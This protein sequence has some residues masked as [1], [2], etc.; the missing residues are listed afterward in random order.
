MRSSMIDD[1]FHDPYKRGVMAD[2]DGEGSAGETECGA[3][4][5]VYIR[6]DGLRISEAAFTASGSKAAI[7]C[8]SVLA[9]MLEGMSWKQA[10][11]MPPASIA[12]AL[13]G[14]EGLREFL[15]CRDAGRP[16]R[17]GS[18]P[19]AAEFA[20]D[21]LHGALEKAISNGSFPVEKA[22]SP[23][24]VIVAMSGGV[25]S[26]VACLL[27]ERSRRDVIGVTMRLWSD[28]LCDN[29]GN[30]SSSCCS[31]RT[32][33]DARSVCQD[34]GVPHLTIDLRERFK[35]SVVE[36]FVSEYLAG[37]TP[38]PCTR[39]NAG[40][41]FPALAE[42]AERLGAAA[43]ATGHYARI[44]KGENAS[45]LARGHDINKDQSYML[46]GIE[47]ALLGKLEF[48]L[49]E[50]DKT[51]T[52]NMARRSSLPVHNRPESQEVCF[53][54]DDDYRRFIA[55]RLSA[56]GGELPGAGDIVD[57]SGNLLGRHSGF[58][59]YTIGQRRGLGISAPEPLYVISSHPPSNLIVVGRREELAVDRLLIGWVNAFYPEA[60][61]AA[62]KAQIR[63]NSPPIP[64]CVDPKPIAATD[65]GADN[66][67]QIWNVKLASP[68]YGVAPGQSVA[69]YR[70][71]TLV[72]GGVI[73]ATGMS[74]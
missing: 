16:P 8:G 72:A 35:E 70:G 4:V 73:E 65:H 43:I 24:R 68:A 53:I 18:M 13:A 58:L 62:D 15:D 23:G 48:P 5:S 3:R 57:S 19:Q 32:I 42:F 50:M 21:A 26:S 49:G 71:D 20:I 37:R 29:A 31:P 28:P 67:P 7:A 66:A 61:T 27:L 34:L 6:F 14:A 2:A 45:A 36:Y 9:K 63:Y 47:P 38:N 41:R 44:V 69:L 39:C 52:R 46:W 10:A 1:H 30:D 11:A 54:P 74:H 64:A 33:R 22:A 51:R 55:S 12:V 40:F 56:A 59:N 60:C 17:Q 25:D